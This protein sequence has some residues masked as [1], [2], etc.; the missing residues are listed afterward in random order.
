MI[1]VII[2]VAVGFYSVCHRVASGKHHRALHKHDDDESIREHER[3]DLEQ[4]R[5]LLRSLLMHGA[6]G[7]ALGGVCTIMGEPQNLLIASKVGW[8]FTEFFVA[9]VPV[10]MPVLVVGLITCL[11]LEL[12]RSFG[13]GAELPASVRKTLEEFDAEESRERTQR[14]VARLVIQAIAAVFLVTALA[15]H[16]A[17]VGLIGLAIIVIQTAL[18]GV[19]NEHQIGHAFQEA[20]PFTALLVVFFAV[21]AVIHDQH[22]FSGVITLVLSLPEEA[23]PA[24]FY[25]ANGVLSA[26]SDNVFVATIYINEVRAAFDAGTISAEHMELLAIA[27]NTGTNTSSVATSNGQA[28]FLFR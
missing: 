13:Y 7:T 8:N 26:I 24:M 9:M 3:E 28:A 15:L 16:V 14:D 18:N 25:V 17:E 12:T 6:V 1:A 27:I 19:T 2:T 20:L 4:F 21:V 11:L 10:S 22:L 5:A 23:Q